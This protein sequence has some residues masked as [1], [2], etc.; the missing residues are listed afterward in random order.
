MELEGKTYE[1]PR[2]GDYTMWGE[3][4]KLFLKEWR[5]R[6]KLFYSGVLLL[7][8][9]LLRADSRKLALSGN[10]LDKKL[11]AQINA[12]RILNQRSTACRLTMGSSL[13]D[14]SLAHRGSKRAD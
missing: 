1:E 4:Q 10:S 2:R 9:R 7:V 8:V 5:Y 11:L 13:T 3:F 12:F 14:A 6:R